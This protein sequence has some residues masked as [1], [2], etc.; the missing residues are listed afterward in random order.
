MID[1]EPKGMMLRVIDGIGL[2]FYLKPL[3]IPCWDHSPR[4]QT[5]SLIRRL[6]PQPGCRIQAPRDGTCRRARSAVL[7]CE[8]QKFWPLTVGCRLCCGL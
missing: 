8:V 1:K 6:G 2:G 7:L 3:W 4:A 5:S